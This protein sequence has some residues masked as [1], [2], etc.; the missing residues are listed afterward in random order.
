MQQEIELITKPMN[1]GDISYDA[2]FEVI[3][4]NPDITPPQLRIIRSQR[5]II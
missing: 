1:Q 3:N 2:E 5:F 4:D